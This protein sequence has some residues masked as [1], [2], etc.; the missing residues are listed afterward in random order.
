MAEFIDDLA[1]DAALD[2]SGCYGDVVAGVRA[3]GQPAVDAFLD[4]MAPLVQD[5]ALADPEAAAKLG[6]FFHSWGV[7]VAA[8]AAVGGPDGLQTA[9]LRSEQSS[10][11]DAAA[12][13]EHLDALLK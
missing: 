8:L 6:R 10:V 2:R 4:G 5:V 13:A 9:I 3:L 11:V 7:T 12:A 1:G